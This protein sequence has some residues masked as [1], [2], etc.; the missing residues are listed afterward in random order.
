MRASDVRT[1]QRGQVLVMAILALVV[2]CGFVSLTIDIGIFLHGRRSVQNAVDAAALAGAQDLPNS[3]SAESIARAYANQND[4]ELSGSNVDVSFRCI[5]GDRDGDS[6]PDSSDVPAVC[7]PGGATFTCSGAI[8]WSY[9]IPGGTNKCN[10]IVVGANKDV[11]FY[12]GP[13]LGVLGSSGCF[14][15]ECNTGAIRAAACR[16]ACG[17]PPG[18]PLD[19]AMV[20]DRTWSMCTTFSNPCNAG[21]LANLNN[22]KNGAKTVLQLLNPNQQHV[23]LGVLPKSPTANDCQ[24][25]T[26]NGQAGNWMI[27]PLSSNY[28]SNG[29]LNSGSELVSNINCM[30]MATLYGTQTDL[31]DPLEAAHL[32]LESSGRPGVKKAIIFL[33]DGA[34]NEPQFSPV[35]GNTGN[36]N[37]TAN[38]AV[39][40]GSG[41][42]NGFQ[43]SPD[44]ACAD[45]GTNAT[46]T[47]SG[48]NTN[49]ACTDTGKDRHIFRDYNVSLPANATIVGIGVRLDGWVDSASGTRRMCAQLSWNGGTSWTT[50]QQTSDMSTSQSTYTLGGSTNT[51]GRSWVA[52]DVTNANF[53]LRV[54]DVGSSTSRDFMLDWAA[55]NVYYTTPSA[56]LGACDYAN[57]KATA[58]KNDEVEIFTIGFGVEGETC[59]Y[60][61]GPYNGE[62]AT[63]ILA[64]MATDSLDDHG[65]CA[66]SSAIDAENADGDHFLCEAKDG[67][68]LGPVFTAAAEVLITGSK[69]V[70]VFD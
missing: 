59:D 39:T 20:I 56:A 32:H 31:G 5:V 60:D 3:T 55:V 1:Q 41:D 2:V 15:D 64:D 46:D 24:S 26:S 7:D 69:L 54:T 43:T 51:W 13:V 4:L 35:N 21:G 14:L 68:S 38:A 42:N 50:A 70:P 67:S 58:A 19:I 6:T 23:G 66:N 37:C 57:Q 53:R 17:L 10:T 11:P 45:G 47:D 25:V 48:T 62:R 36:L 28:S 61:S 63:E 27:T 12:F 29:V 49:T 33:T 8:C 9:C 18:I 16:G 30:Q 34:A 65:H 52:N 40:S 22:A 44:S